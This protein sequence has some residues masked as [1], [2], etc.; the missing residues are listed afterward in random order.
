MGLQESHHVVARAVGLVTGADQCDGIHG[1]KYLAKRCGVCLRHGGQLS[2]GFPVR[3]NPD[4]D[5]A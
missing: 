1:F 3:L 2:S 5:L 4:G